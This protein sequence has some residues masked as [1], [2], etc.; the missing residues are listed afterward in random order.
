MT[1]SDITG[2]PEIKDEA[3]HDLHRPSMA[4][5]LAIPPTIEKHT[6]RM[7][8]HGIGAPSTS[9][10]QSLPLP[11]SARGS[12]R[13]LHRERRSKTIGISVALT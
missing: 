11:R 3:G 1:L 6:G 2:F 10:H 9:H 7:E 4:R 8:A 5:L 12:G 13:E